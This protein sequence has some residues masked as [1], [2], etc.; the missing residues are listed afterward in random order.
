[1]LV[2]AVVG[3]V[4]TRGGA[5][6]G[7]PELGRACWAA[8]SG[9]VALAA[10]PAAQGRKFPRAARL[11]RALGGYA[12]GAGAGGLGD[13][14]PER[15]MLGAFH[16]DGGAADAHAYAHGEAHADGS[17]ADASDA[18]VAGAAPARDGGGVGVARAAAARRPH[19]GERGGDAS[20]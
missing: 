11:A 16:E 10:W 20:P 12:L 2:S 17:W 5:S 1:V 6:V 13:V 9:A 3:G 8:G 14:R 4:L 19:G 15:I 7:G 18:S